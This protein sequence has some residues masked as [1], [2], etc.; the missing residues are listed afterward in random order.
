MEDDKSVSR[1]HMEQK[2]NVYRFLAEKSKRKDSL[3]T[4][5]YVGV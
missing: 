4:Q 3:E 1:A 2:K 5:A